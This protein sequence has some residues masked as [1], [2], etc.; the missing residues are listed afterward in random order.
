MRLID[1]NELPRTTRERFVRSLVSDS[2]AARPLCKRT[3]KPRSRLAWVVLVV[4]VVVAI[5]G[6]SQA[7]FGA[8]H[9]PVQ[10]RRF[11][12]G[13]VLFWAALGLALS[14]LARRRA[15][16][17]S[18]PFTPGVY[19][20]PLDLVDARTRDLELHPLSELQALDP[21]HH[22]KGGKYTHSTL[23]FVFPTKSFAFE[24]RGLAAAT[25]QLTAVQAAREN[26]AAALQRGSLDELSPFDPFADARARSFEPAHDHGLL[27]RGRPMWTRFIWA[28]TVI[29]GLLGGVGWWRLRNWQS[30]EWAFRRLESDPDIALVDAYLHGG[31]LRAAEVKSVVLPRARLAEAKKEPDGAERAVAIERFLLAYPKSAVEEEARAALAD[32]LHAD[33]LTQKTVSGLRAFIARWP[34]ARDVPAANVKIRDLYRETIDDFQ[35]HANAADKSVVPIVLGLLTYSE[36][37]ARPIEVRFRRRGAATLA[38]ADSLLAKGL[39]DDD[40]PTPGGNAEV[41]PHLG[42]PDASRREAALVVGLE[43][44]FATV[45]PA[46][47]V[48]LKLGPPLEEAEAPPPG[49]RPLADV[50]APTIVID[51]EVGWAGTTYVARDSRRRYLGVSVRFDLAVQIPNEARVLA[52]SIKVEPPETFPIDDVTHDPIF[53]ALVPPGPRSASSNDSG[54]YGVMLLRAFDQMAARMM[55]VVFEPRTAAARAPLDPGAPPV[56]AQ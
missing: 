44:S 52:L 14:M 3:S 19:V 40:G 33:F 30:D 32:A 54:V 56:A 10:D 21:V 25:Q 46:G 29:V 31:G 18:L 6:L 12:G 20:F 26:L 48:A 22:T 7:H 8:A 51:Y 35:T 5:V 37:Q 49:T 39:L 27:A 4:V 28:L 23:W 1:F 17:G 36:E 15:I 13:Y 41:S 55:S 47:V 45:F 11:L 53:Q 38:S 34:D 42:G 50:S 9:A 2:P 16:A 43:R 24:I